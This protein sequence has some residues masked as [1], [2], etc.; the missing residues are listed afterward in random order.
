MMELMHRRDSMRLV[1]AARSR[2]RARLQH[3]G[4]RTHN[5]PARDFTAHADDPARS[6]TSQRSDE[7]AWQDPTE[8]LE[9]VL[10]LLNQGRFGVCEECGVGIKLE[11]LLATPWVTC[12]AA[13][14][15]WRG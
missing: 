2:E 13:C 4:G 9:S 11:R 15:R 8:D 3:T 1:S 6:E 12:C 5:S 10:R 14:E 7:D